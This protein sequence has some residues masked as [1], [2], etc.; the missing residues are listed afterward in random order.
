MLS[1]NPASLTSG[2]NGHSTATPVATVA[3]ANYAPYD[4]TVSSLLGRSSRK[5]ASPRLLSGRW[6]PRANWWR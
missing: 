1:L 3:D 2:E 4:L 6:L 5:M